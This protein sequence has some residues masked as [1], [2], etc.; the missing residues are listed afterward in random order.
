[1]TDHSERGF[2]LIEL[3]ITILVMGIVMGF[4][5][6]AFQRISATYQLRGSA[7]DLAAQLRLARE[8]AIATGVEQP[9]HLPSTLTGGVYRS[10]HVHY[11]TPTNYISTQWMLPNGIAFTSA[12][13][14]KWYRMKS[15]GRCD[16]SGLIVLRDRRGNRDTVSVQLSGLVLTR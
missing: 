10:Y 5:I 16:N 7:E 3:A 2:T 13:V 1:M 14:N 9:I 8:K 6:P 15:D 11:E 12:S 4:S